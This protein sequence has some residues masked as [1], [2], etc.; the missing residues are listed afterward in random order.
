MVQ[1]TQMVEMF[2]R[3]LNSGVTKETYKNIVNSIQSKMVN[4][5]A[6]KEALNSAG[7]KDRRKIAVLL[8]VTTPQDAFFASSMFPVLNEDVNEKVRIAVAQNANCPTEVLYHLSFDQSL[9]IQRA[10]GVHA[11]TSVYTLVKMIMVEL[12]TTHQTSPWLLSSIKD[13]TPSVFLNPKLSPKFLTY[14][15]DNYKRYS[16]PVMS[17]PNY[18]I[19]GIYDYLM[20]KKSHDAKVAKQSPSTEKR[21]MEM[22]SCIIFMMAEDALKRRREELM[23]WATQKHQKDFSGFSDEDFIEHVFEVTNS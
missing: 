12:N 18:P 23:E 16:F 10:V 21:Y 8:N 15:T 19:G 22:S 11:N 3:M 7:W 4:F 5:D 9:E 1:E 14:L 6:F 2:T 17:H 13:E 20:A